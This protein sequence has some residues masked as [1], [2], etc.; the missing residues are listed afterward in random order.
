MKAATT[1]AS[2]GW[3]TTAEWLARSGE[4]SNDKDRG[5]P[6][7]ETASRSRATRGI[8]PG[9]ENRCRVQ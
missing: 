3:E 6:R 2:L 5:R 9:D 7:F 4:I 8:E 1:L